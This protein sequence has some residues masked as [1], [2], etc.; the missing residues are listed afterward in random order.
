MTTPMAVMGAHHRFADGRNRAGAWGRSFAEEMAEAR[1]RVAAAH[2]RTFES[3]WGTVE[4][5]D[6]GD[7]QP[8]FMSHG[9]LG[10]HDN[11]RELVDLW[12]GPQYRA[13]GPSRFGYLGSVMPPSAT[14][15]MQADAYEA[16]LD[17]LCVDRVVLCGFSAGGPAAIQFALRHPNRLHGLV[18][19]S[20]YLPGMGARTVPKPILPV[21][22]G[23]IGWERGWWNLKQ[24]CPGVLARIMGVPKSWDPGGD[25]VFLSIRQ[26]LFP[27]RPKRFGVAFDAVVSEPASNGF[28][29]EDISVRTLFVHAADDRLAPYEHVEPAVKRV[30]D[31]RL[32][33]IECGGHLF[34]EHAEEVRQ[35]TSAFIGDLTATQHLTAG[36]V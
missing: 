23:V 35:A 16:L 3:P 20:S 11:V 25:E 33:T 10:G 12:F 24:H 34:L 14:V 13:I 31:A 29:L 15:G 28:P 18:L 36:G 27:I 17:H 4:F 6:D 19:G 5:L 22:R 8:V 7:G 21:V 2:S 30:P 26:A 9:V 32:V 1:R